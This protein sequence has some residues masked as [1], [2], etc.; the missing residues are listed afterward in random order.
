MFRIQMKHNEKDVSFNVVC[1]ENEEEIEGLI[2]IHLETL[3]KKRN[4]LNG[5]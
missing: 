3:E 4:T 2:A 5:N 1:A